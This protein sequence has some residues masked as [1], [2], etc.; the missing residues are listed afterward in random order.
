MTLTLPISFWNKIKAVSRE[1][2]GGDT[3]AAIQVD[4][5]P[6][7]L[8]LLLREEL[9]GAEIIVVSNREPYIH[10]GLNGKTTLQTPASGLV[11]ALEPIMRACGGTWIA[12][13]GGSADRETA[14]SDSRIEVP[15][16]APA[17]T[18]RRI[19]LTDEEQ[20]GYY[21]GFAN[22]G[23]WPL[24][25]N[26]FVR[27]AFRE[28]D[29]HCY[30]MVNQRFADA[31][32]QEARSENPIVLVQDYHLALVPHFLQEQLPKA[33]IL[34]F[35]HIPWP[36][37]ETF[38]ICPWRADL[39]RG[40]LDSTI[41]GFHT[42]WHCNNFLETVDRFIESR[43]DREQ[44]SVCVAGREALVRAY[45]ISI[46]WPPVALSGQKS[47]EEC[48]RLVRS[49]IGLAEDVCLAVGVERFDY[50]KGIPERMRAVNAFLTRYPEW[51]GRFALLQVAAPTR[52]KLA[53]Y[54]DLQNQVIALADEINSNHSD[55]GWKPIHLIIR[56]HSPHDVFRLFRA[57]DLCLV[58]SLHDGMS[59]VAKEFV[60][61]RNDG[62]GVL[63][64]SSFAGASREL[65]EALIVNPFDT[66]EVGE[67]IYRAAC[68]S[69]IEQRER[70]RLM[71]A[72]LQSRNVY[73]WAGQMLID[74]A[75]VR[76][77]QRIVDF[78]DKD[79]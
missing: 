52:T 30:R 41:L 38:G 26:A 75:S 22:E 6:Q 8:Q 55:G 40:M 57:A 63:I 21:F 36:N 78:T 54:Q 64:L 79:A 1:F 46:E 16:G 69:E 76:K 58:T 68:M 51:K 39:I 73:R 12:H 71:R 15:P 60:A 23:I 24:C 56:H 37:A 45:P 49:E 59:L 65:T 20:D 34:T 50:T 25:H 53:T 47:V 62:L 10:N 66:N 77:R 67:A 19:W 42:R 28:S 48:R 29:W 33:T 44:A 4:W 17:Y 13:G 27:P 74:A 14:G 5:S 35:W 61:A 31:V 9:P 70:M 43:I 2:H 11:S 72:H 7:T 3:A 32:I 18:L